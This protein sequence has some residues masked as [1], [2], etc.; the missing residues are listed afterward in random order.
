MSTRGAEQAGAR[1]EE[2]SGPA[3]HRPGQSGRTAGASRSQ[4]H[5]LPAWT[6]P[7]ITRTAL[8]RPGTAAERRAGSRNQGRCRASVSATDCGHTGQVPGVPSPSPAS[9]L[10]FSRPQSSPVP[11]AA[12]CP[13]RSGLQQPLGAGCE[14]PTRRD[15]IQRLTDAPW[16]HTGRGGDQPP[17]REPRAQP[18]LCRRHQSTEATSASRCPALCWGAVAVLGR[19]K[20]HWDMAPQNGP[21]MAPKPLLQVPQ[22]TLTP[23]PHKG[24]DSWEPLKMARTQSDELQGHGQHCPRQAT[25]LAALRK[26]DL[27]HFALQLFL[28]PLH[29]PCL[30]E[31]PHGKET[32]GP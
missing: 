27:F 17:R 25:N 2:P 28:G 19:V 7:S 24:L 13:G 21:H 3:T 14:C 1:A 9:P 31:G 30:R 12:Q 5:K 29:T 32:A 18:E 26:P 16:V 22:P 11:L 15:L 10:P 20:G 4:Q 23:G 8:L 6:L